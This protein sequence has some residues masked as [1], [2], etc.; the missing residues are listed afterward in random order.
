MPA[1]QFSRAIE[2]NRLRF[3]RQEPAELRRIPWVEQDK[4]PVNPESIV[5]GVVVALGTLVGL[6][7]AYGVLA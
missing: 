3:L 2:T 7:S 4:P 1:P 5:L 6:L